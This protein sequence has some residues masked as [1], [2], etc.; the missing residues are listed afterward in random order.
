MIMRLFSAALGG[1]RVIALLC[2]Q[3]A[4][5][6]VCTRCVNELQSSPRMRIGHSTKY[7]R[8]G[9]Q[10][11]AQNAVDGTRHERVKLIQKPKKVQTTPV[12]NHR[13]WAKTFQSKVPSLGHLCLKYYTL[14]ANNF[15][16][17]SPTSTAADAYAG[18]ISR[19]LTGRKRH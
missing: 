7:S 8:A 18:V 6:I 11:P 14:A 17:L 15:I 19:Q 13:R 9:P 16:L 12:G 4:G 3:R 2:G 10:P 1:E 5:E